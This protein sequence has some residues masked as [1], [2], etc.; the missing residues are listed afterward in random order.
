MTEPAARLAAALAGRY[1]LAGEL[2]RGA[3][4]TVYLAD[5]VRH[6][7]RVA[8]K[9]LHPEVA[10]LLG[11]ERFLREVELAARFTHPHILALYDSGAAAEWLFYVMPY[12]AGGSLRQRL[13]RE[14]QLPV[15]EAV[16]I[17][18]QIAGALGYAH[19]QGVLH[20]DVKPENILLHEGEA[21]LADFG[22][23]LAVRA[24]GDE[25]LTATGLAVGTPEY[26]S[27]EQALAERTLD[28]RSDVYALACVLYEM[29]AGEPPYTAPTA[30]ALV[31][32]RL[33]DPVP[34]VRRL[35]PAV[36]A[37]VEQALLTALARAP[38]DRFATAEAFAA[39]LQAPAAPRAASVAVLPFDNLS[40]DPEN[41]YFADGITED[42]IAH[43][44]KVAALK[45]IAR[46]SVMAFKHRERR[47]R[48]IGATLDVTTL[49]VGSVRRA[50]DRV[51]IVA[52]LVDAE[53]ERP[54]WAETYDRR[55]TDIFEIQTDVALHIAAALRAELS[56]DERTRIRKEPTRDLE[57]YQLYLQGRRWFTEYTPAG[58][59][60]A[61]AYFR[62]AIERDPGYALAHAATAMA[63]ADLGE[64]GA[65]APSVASA[66]ARAAVDEALRLDP[67]LGEA[68]CA[69]AYVQLLWEFDWAGAE[70]ELRRALELSPNSADAYD[71][72]GR[73]CAGLGRYDEALTLQRRAQELDPLAH[74]VDVATTLLRAG[75]FDEAAEGARRAAALDP[76]QSRAHATLGWALLGQG[77]A[78]E[79]IAALERAAA[80]APD[81]TQWLAQLGQAYAVV[82]RA[83]D[84]R[85]VLRRLEERARSAYVS[86]YHLAFVHTGL[87]DH[88]RALDLLERAVAERGGALYGIKG[89]F[90]FAPLRG[91]PRFGALLGRLGLA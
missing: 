43:L 78:A 80:L 12:V 42:V 21:M 79:G 37:H 18:G 91:E 39:A 34:R 51:R 15:E 87:G 6:G 47:L 17:A 33:T 26:M 60:R 36:P 62:R 76:D 30:P 20:R 28:A 61:I 11:P 38:A 67:A 44:A 49:L 65:L 53:T 5:D 9:V 84:A 41:E 10:A 1:V 89:S 13:E 82:G 32:K 64:S 57:A 72:Y 7:R 86:P 50:G 25:R 63:Y 88:E 59:E 27:P 31:A 16:R 58:L 35:R 14:G 56:A 19:R 40:A 71:L 73:M 77:R 46:A 90:L 66:R 22:I 4:A 8:L 74:R 68:R 23:A 69:L 54:V 45:V 3:M 81:D 29:L 85:E 70:R 48:E 55:L 52:Q 83:A 75:R 2:G 24:A